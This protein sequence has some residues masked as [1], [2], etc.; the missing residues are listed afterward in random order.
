MLI[1]PFASGVPQVSDE[2]VKGVRVVFHHLSFTSVAA[3]P[4]S[5]R[6]GTEALLNYL[7]TSR[8]PPHLDSDSRSTGFTGIFN[9]SDSFSLCPE[10]SNDK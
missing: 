9:G 3:E 8:P 4:Q 10:L 1:A 2:P 6:A 5:H 7:Q